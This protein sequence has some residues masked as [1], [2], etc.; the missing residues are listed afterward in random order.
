VDERGEL[1]AMHG[2]I[3]GFDVGLHTDVLDG[4]PRAKGLVTA[5]R[6]LTPEALVCDE[7]STEADAEAVLQVTGCGVPLLASAH[8]GTPEEVRRRPLLRNLL[9]QGAFAYVAFLSRDPVGQVERLLE[10]KEFL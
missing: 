8:G 6:V 4:F 5:L 7:I 9:Q 2:G 3:P 1:A 10:G